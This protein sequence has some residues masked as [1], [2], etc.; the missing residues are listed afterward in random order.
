MILAG[1]VGEA[2][3]VHDPVGL[4]AT[5]RAP[6]VVDERLLEPDQLLR[7]GGATDG[8]VRPGRLPEPVLRRAARPAAGGG[9]V[10]PCA[11]AVAGDEE[12]PLAL[13]D[14]GEGGELA[15]VMAVEMDGG[16]DVEFELLAVD[17]LLQIDRGRDR[18]MGWE[19]ID[20]RLGI[21]RPAG[22][23]GDRSLTK[24]ASISLSVASGLHSICRN[25]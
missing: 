17:H 12:V 24:R 11:G 23:E 13:A 18:L 19:V 22:V 6:L 10:L 21:Y 7:V 2:I 16:D 8:S 20:R 3:L 14:A 9:S 15:R 4:G 25:S 5:W 1:G